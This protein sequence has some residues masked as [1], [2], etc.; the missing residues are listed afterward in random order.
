VI[1]TGVPLPGR[2]TVN[3]FFAAN[4]GAPYNITTGLDPLDTGFPSARPPGVDRNA[5]RGPAA[6][7]LALR[8]SR[9]WGFGE[10][11]ATQQQDTTHP[12]AM[13]APSGHRYSLTLTASTLNALNHPNYGPP[14]GN[15]SSPYFGQSRSLGGFMVTAHDGTPS[16]YNR[17]VDLQLRVTF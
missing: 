3:P 10:R 12:L 2:I 9:T 4:S 15:L 1:G 6:V 16:T 5:A 17:K 14:E 11:T 13:T 8:V 7:N